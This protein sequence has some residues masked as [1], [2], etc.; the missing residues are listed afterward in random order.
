MITLGVET[1]CDETSCSVLDSNPESQ[2]ILTNIISSQIKYHEPFGGVVPSI[3][4]REHA[5]NLPIVFNKSIRDIGINDINLISVTCGPG[6]I[7][8]LLA[9]VTFAKTLSW[10]YKI[11]I[12]GVNH[13]EGHVHS[14]F[15]NRPDI[16]VAEKNIYPQVC[17]IVSGGHTALYRIPKPG[18]I[19]RILG[20]GYP[21]GPAISKA[22]L[23]GEHGIFSLPRPMSKTKNYNFS[24]S[25]LKTSVLYL[26]KKISPSGNYSDLKKQTM[27]DIALE[28]QEAIVDVLT[29][30]TIRLAKETKVKSVIVAGGVSANERLREEI[31]SRAA[32][33][34][35]PPLV[36]MPAP[37]FSTDNAAMI[38]M[39]GYHRYI[40]SRCGKFSWE[41][42][43]AEADLELN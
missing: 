6:L 9:G 7:S 40:N 12:I 42:V 1:S 3:A 36:L 22:A 27:A 14:V 17:L 19:S 18:K 29:S 30:K 2:K 35:P 11:P 39:A 37:E 13:L 32:K 28:A 16:N 25:G 20:L 23:S 34:N 10:K 4:A 21:G 15:I 31:I 43:K 33:I 24:F 38:A 8:S 5:I 26:V 41:K